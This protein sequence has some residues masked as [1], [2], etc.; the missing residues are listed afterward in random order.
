MSRL[1]IAPTRSNLIQTKK[2]LSFARKGYEILDKKRE[3][4]TTELMHLAHD[5]DVLQNQVW[6][7]LDSAYRS[8]ENARLTVGQERVEWASLAVNK[9]TEVEIKNRGVMGVPIPIVE[10]HG[11]PPEMTYSMGDTLATLDDASYAFRI[12][13]NRVPE[14]TEIMTSVW[15]LARELRKTQRRVNAL[16]YIF[17]PDYEDTVTFIENTLEERERE[18]TFRLKLLK[19]RA[20]KETLDSILPGEEVLSPLC[21]GTEPENQ[22]SDNY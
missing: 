6:Q 10:S 20:D 7:Q 3:V 12:V 15:R 16:K 8:L 9:S 13:L 22:A 1:N 19:T 11:E 21:S 17:I 14:L 2:D 18:E 4:L 5:A